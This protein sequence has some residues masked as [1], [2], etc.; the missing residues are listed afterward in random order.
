MA[1]DLRLSI[2]LPASPGSSLCSRSGHP[3]E[4]PSRPFDGPG[5]PFEETWTNYINANQ[6]KEAHA[7]SKATPCSSTLSRGSFASNM[8][9]DSSWSP[10]VYPVSPTYGL[11]PTAPAVPQLR[12]SV[13]R[14]FARDQSS[15]NNSFSRTSGTTSSEMTPA[16]ATYGH[17]LGLF[18]DLMQNKASATP[19]SYDTPTSLDLEDALAALKRYTSSSSGEVTSKTMQR[20]ID[21]LT[22]RFTLEKELDS[23]RTPT[24]AGKMAESETSGRY[25][26]PHRRHDSTSE[27]GSPWSAG[28][29]TPA[30]VPLPAF[31]DEPARVRLPFGAT[32]EQAGRPRIPVVRQHTKRNTSDHDKENMPGPGRGLVFSNKLAAPDLSPGASDDFALPIHQLPRDSHLG[33]D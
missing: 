21:A 27:I 7:A 24:I 13:P 14:S 12:V 33:L 22:S 4:D 23:L 31:H 2:G 18:P 32:H 28:L 16:P 1:D 6:S 19:S 25:L 3:F 29:A 8:L 20:D 15:S 10:P 30:Q 9:A 11:T 5:Q 17:R 26:P